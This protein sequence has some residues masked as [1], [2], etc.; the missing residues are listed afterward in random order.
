M[1][2]TSN[3]TAVTQEESQNPQVETAKEKLPAETPKSAK[4]E[5]DIEDAPF[6]KEEGES[7]QDESPDAGEGDG[8]EKPAL[9][10]KKK[11]LIIIGAAALLLLLGGA[12]AAWFLLKPGTSAPPPPVVEEIK[13]EVI[14]V[15]TKQTP[16]VTPDVVTPLEQFIVPVGDTLQKTNFLICKFSIIS[17]DM[18]LGSEIDNKIIPLRDAVYF[19]LRS[20]SYDYL[21][22][23]ANA[24][25]IKSD[26]VGILNDFLTT[27]KVEDV[28]LDTYLGH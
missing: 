22:T 3:E 25:D 17:K 2:Q 18:N 28:L 19:Y 16:A 26:L 12:S 9:S 4:V 14:V 27:G 5:L 20:K 8:Q 7:H 23:P 15:P 10:S 6:L 21:L 11:K 1:S 24:K 13:P